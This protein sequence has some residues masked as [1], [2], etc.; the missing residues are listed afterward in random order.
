MELKFEDTLNQI[1]SILKQFR[2]VKPIVKLHASQLP[3]NIKIKKKKNKIDSTIP[4]IQS[5]SIIEAINNSDI[6]IV[7]TPESFGTSTML[8][9]SM[10]LRKPTMNIILDDNLFEFEY[11]KDNAVLSIFF[12]DQLETNLKNILFNNEIKNN[13]IKNGKNHIKNYLTNPGTS[14]KYFAKIIDSF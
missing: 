14:S 8:L 9:E 12:N 10:I 5:F 6:V 1:F 3:H 2:N 13:L 7:I 11:V 4:I